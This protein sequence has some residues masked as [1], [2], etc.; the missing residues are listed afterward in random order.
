MA[1]LNKRTTHVNSIREIRRF[2]EG[3]DFA[4]ASVQRLGVLRTSLIRHYDQFFDSHHELIDGGIAQAEFDVHE[5]LKNEIEGI[6]NNTE[7]EILEQIAN[8]NRNNQPPAQQ[9]AQPQNNIDLIAQKI[10]NVWGEFDGTQW[11][12][13]TFR[14]IF[15]DVVHTSEM[16]NSI[17]FHHL[18]K[19]L[20][21]EAADV[22]GNWAI[23]NDNY[24]LAWARL[25]EVYEHTHQAGTELLQ[26]LNK[27]PQLTRANRKD[28]QHLSNVANDVKR[29][30][31]ALGY[32]TNHWDLVFI[33]TIEQKLDN[34]T[35]IAWELE[36]NQDRPT[37]NELLR[38]IEKQARAL[39]CL[40]Y[41]P[42][43]PRDNRKRFGDK[44][45][46]IHEQ[47]KFI[48][49]ENAP[50]HKSYTPTKCL[51]PGCNA[52]HVLYKCQQ[53][54]AKN[55]ED[56]DKFVKKNRLCINC[57]FPGHYA[58]QCHR[59]SCNRCQEKHNSTLCTK[60]P[61]LKKTNVVQ[62]APLKPEQN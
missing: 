45:D 44:V 39:A 60:N 32:D 49:V 46:H 61:F 31:T 12:W 52:I 48:K 38:F 35:K 2:V 28:L 3:N 4:N 25:N 51:I 30:V 13:A 40:P 24:P 27:L 47:K 7:T 6:K 57:L 23:T 26:R 16:S 55:R 34:R 14:D 53:Y 22:L 17:K 29:Q 18:K 19:S 37:L 50:T 1:A 43:K 33:T 21:G 10:E 20:K 36:R 59:G 54:L 56:R 42:S 9:P 11:K 62:T 15:R 5:A 8:V 58:K 41:E